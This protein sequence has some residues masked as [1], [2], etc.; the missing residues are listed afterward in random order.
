MKRKLILSQIKKKK[1]ISFILFI[2]TNP[3]IQNFFLVLNSFNIK[4]LK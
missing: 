2:Y 4:L 1:K 3:L